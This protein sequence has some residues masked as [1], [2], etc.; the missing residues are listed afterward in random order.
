MLIY[1]FI[2]KIELNKEKLKGSITVNGKKVSGNLPGIDC[3]ITIKSNFSLLRIL[4]EKDIGLGKEYRDENIEID[5]LT[6]FIRFL[7]QN[8]GIFGS[9]NSN[10][11]N[12]VKHY[13]NKNTKKKAKKNIEAHYDLGNDFYSLWL[14][15]TMTYSSAYWGEDKNKSLKEAQ[16]SKYKLYTDNLIGNSVLEIG[17]GWGGFAKSVKQNYPNL[18]YKGLSLSNQQTEFAKKYGDVIIQDY[19]DHVGK[20]D[21]IVSIEMFEAVGK[22]YWDSYFSKVKDCL[23]DNGRAQIQVIT[24]DE[25]RYDAYKD[26]SDF[27][28]HFIFPGGFLP[29]KKLFIEYANKYGLVEESSIEFPLDYAKTLKMWHDNFDSNIEK[30]KSLGYDDKFIRIWKMYLAMCEASFEERTIGLLKTT[31]KLK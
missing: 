3:D 16:E 21:N 13:F 19:R 10:P 28:K 17:A 12:I 7:L 25:K 22:E 20:Y 31:F 6:S 24:I 23:N 11:I 27:I 4:F 9:D 2:K 30:I 14:D 18:S 5:N 26:N 1:G 15:E 29:T 8:E